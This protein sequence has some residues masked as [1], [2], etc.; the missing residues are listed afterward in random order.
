[1]RL[2][3]ISIIAAAILMI[4][5]CARPV[6]N[7]LVEGDGQSAPAD[8]EFKNESKRAD[9][10]LWDFGDG[11]QSTEENPAH[12][13][14]LSGRYTV[15]LDAIKGKKTNTMEK[16]IHVE[17]PHNCLVLIETSL[18]NMEVLLYDST[19][20]HRDNFIKL[21]EEGFY[22]SLLFH[23]VIQGF[24]IQG[25]DPES[26]GADASKR[27]GAG[28]PGYQIDAE[29]NKENLHFKGAL[30][31]ARMG[32]QVNPEKKS[33]GSQFYIVQG[34]PVSPDML[35]R[36]EMQKGIRYSPDQRKTYQTEGG[37]PFLDM[38]YTVFG[39]VTKGM[40][41]IDKIAAVTTLPGD[42]PAEDVWMKISV[43]K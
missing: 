28:G 2:L 12:R 21:A 23:R 19:P 8:V 4:S 16:D 9:V 29:F 31:A 27:L 39:R 17:A 24:M 11:K 34:T 38:D 36:I 37:T 3:T 41:V 18:G 15:K 13:F 33:S 40:D 7:F 5:G 14:V 25:G 35:E 42:R 30:S 6:A 10:F 20:K 32:D 22:D 26:K 43:V 1:M